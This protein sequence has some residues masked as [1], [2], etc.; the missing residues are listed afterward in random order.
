VPYQTQGPTNAPAPGTPFTITMTPALPPGCS[1]AI[2]INDMLALP[3]S[4]IGG[5]KL[6]GFGSSL[7]NATASLEATTKD[8]PATIDFAI[9]CPPKGRRPTYVSHKVD[10]GWHPPGEVFDPDQ[11]RPPPEPC[12]DDFAPTPGYRKRH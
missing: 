7:D 11:G 6:L 12:G 3:G 9:I 8:P 10:G 1:L 4:S 2:Y 5:V